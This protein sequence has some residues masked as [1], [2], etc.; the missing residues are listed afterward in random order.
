MR[1]WKT[2]LDN[3]TALRHVEQYLRRRS[4][5]RSTALHYLSDLRQFQKFC[6]KPWADVT[7]TD[8]D[9]FVDV[10]QAQGWSVA[11][12]Q[13]RVAA[14]KV[15]F[16]F[17]AEETDT[18]DRPNPVQP[19]RHAPRRGQRL[20]RDV[21]EET[22]L[23]LWAVID[24]P[25]DQVWFTL[26]LR[27]GLRVGEVV[28]LK[29][30]DILAPAT[31]SS[32]ARLRVE[33]KGRKERVV[34]LT[35]DAY[36]VLDRWLQEGPGAA[37]TPLCPNHRGQPMTVNGLQERLR[38]YCQKAGV[39]VTCHQLRRHPRTGRRQYTRLVSRSAGSSRDDACVFL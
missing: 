29:R 37:D 13:R 33:G 34:C 11:T 20:P 39:A 27:A 7:L 9:A 31:T 24:H 38:H 36:A 19:A 14:L 5:D 21:G 26:M 16:E 30:A 35:A 4:P 12:R 10:G 32:P 2:T 17:C 25:R 15:F 1:Y 18:L 23:Q 3:T 6:V 22:L 28:R 8:I